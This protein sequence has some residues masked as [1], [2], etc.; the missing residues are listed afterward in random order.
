MLQILIQM[1]LHHSC[2]LPLL[3]QALQKL[4]FFIS[5]L[6]EFEA[7]SW[8]FQ[9]IFVSF[10]SLGNRVLFLWNAFWTFKFIF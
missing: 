5:M 9:G 10:N 8:S 7:V 3:N 1:V 6:V 2:E 4:Y